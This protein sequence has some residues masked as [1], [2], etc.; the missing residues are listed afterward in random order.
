MI[1]AYHS[2][3]KK[4]IGKV[5][6]EGVIRP[7]IVRLD[8]YS[9][10]CGVVL[11]W[12]KN[13][14]QVPRGTEEMFLDWVEREKESLAD[15]QRQEGFKGDQTS[16]Q[17]QCLDFLAGDIESVFLSLGSW[18][19]DPFP[20]TGLIFDA[21]DLVN[22]GAWIRRHDFADGY[23][24]AMQRVLSKR[25]TSYQKFVDKAVSDLDFVKR[26]E[27]Y[28]PDALEFIREGRWRDSYEGTPELLWSG[29]LPADWGAV[30]K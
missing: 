26:G 29:D 17:F 11:E 7:A 16:T 12:F 22:N 27:L 1:P 5:L 19:G 9:F 20:K 23:E 25:Y 13:Y 21:E 15:F 3:K 4:F 28:G 8:P 10:D 2:I 18:A 30:A 14:V 24:M 6:R